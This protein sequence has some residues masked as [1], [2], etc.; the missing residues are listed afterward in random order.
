MELCKSD[1]PVG[2]D[3][4]PIC[5]PTIQSDTFQTVVYRA[6]SSMA[7]RFPVLLNR[8]QGSKCV[9]EGADLGGIAEARGS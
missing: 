5:M 6:F 9:S 1:A 4:F 2:D 3:P 7:L 8:F